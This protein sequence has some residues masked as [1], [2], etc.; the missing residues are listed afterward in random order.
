RARTDTRLDLLR[1]DLAYAHSEGAVEEAHLDKPSA[2]HLERLVVGVV[3]MP[4]DHDLGALLPPVVRH[5]ID[6][7]HVEARDA[8]ARGEAERAE[9]AR[10]DQPGL[11]AGV[12]GNA[13]ARRLLELFDGH[14]AS[15]RLAHGLERFGAHDRAAE[16]CQ[17]ARGV[18]RGAHPEPI[19]D[20]HAPLLSPMAR[21][22]VSA[23]NVSTAP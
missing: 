16:P 2:R 20:G 8:R 22:T 15:R 11:G 5:A 1:L 21:S 7:P 19:V 9:G 4:A 3:V 13:P 17:R 18:D 12:A 6:A 10:G 14:R 23:I